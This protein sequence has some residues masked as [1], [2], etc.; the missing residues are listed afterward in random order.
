MKLQIAQQRSVETSCAKQHQM[1]NVQNW[2]KINFT[3]LHKVPPS[4]PQLKGITW[5]SSVLNFTK[6]SHEIWKFLVLI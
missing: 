1:E 5:R 2:A 3:P 4:L 6:I